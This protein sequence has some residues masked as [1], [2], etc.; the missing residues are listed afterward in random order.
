[1]TPT[2]MTALVRH[3]RK[4]TNP[5]AYASVSD[6]ELLER[7][8][9]RRDEAAFELLVWRHQRLVLGVC[10]R[11]RGNVHEAEDAFQATFLTLA[12][13][14]LGGR[15]HNG[16]QAS[17]NGPTRRAGMA[18]AMGRSGQGRRRQGLCGN[19]SHVG[20]RPDRDRSYERA[21]AS[22]S[23]GRF[24]TAGSFVHGSGQ[25]RVCRAQGSGG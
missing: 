20:R 15:R 8:V 13:P 22:G 14:F 11:V 25:R 19:G 12:G 2:S 10:R 17:P 9:D 3:L 5:C 6:A 4:I 1:M 7:F 23:S 24:G 18:S 21:A 16:S